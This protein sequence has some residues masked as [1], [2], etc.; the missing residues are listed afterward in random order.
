MKF[1]QVR[2]IEFTFISQNL[3]LEKKSLSKQKM[4]F[5]N[6]VNFLGEKWSAELRKENELFLFAKK[7]G[8]SYR[9]R[10]YCK[11]GN[12][13]GKDE[14]LSGELRKNIGNDVESILKIESIKK[15]NINGV[16]AQ[17]KIT[18]DQ[19]EIMEKSESHDPSKKSE[20]SY[21]EVDWN[22]KIK[23]T[24]WNKFH[25]KFEEEKKNYGITDEL[26]TSTLFKIYSEEQQIQN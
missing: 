12:K 22:K 2:E 4:T 16:F 15:R 10:L 19:K 1:V 23:N 26:K 14:F 5:N 24:D 6:T 8:D 13:F 7:D 20:D 11:E 17:E 3:W 18:L 9:I 25:Q 21:S